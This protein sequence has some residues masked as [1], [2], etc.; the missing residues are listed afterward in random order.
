MY[1]Y[2]YIYTCICMPQVGLQA[3]DDRVRDD[4]H[5]HGDLQEAGISYNVHNVLWNLC[6]LPLSYRYNIFSMDI[7]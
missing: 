1:I 4:E 2:I 5:G 7:I 6:V 3:D